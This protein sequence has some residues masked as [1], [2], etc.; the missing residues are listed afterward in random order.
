MPCVYKTAYPLHDRPRS[1]LLTTKFHRR[2]RRIVASTPTAPRRACTVPPQP[3]AYFHPPNGRKRRVRPQLSGPPRTFCN[4]DAMHASE[5]LTAVRLR[6][7]HFVQPYP[8]LWIPLLGVAPPGA[9]RGVLPQVDAAAK[10]WQGVE[11]GGS[12]RHAA[13]FTAAAR[14]APLHSFGQRGRLRCACISAAAPQRF[15]WRVPIPVVASII[16]FLRYMQ[17][18]KLRH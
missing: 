7:H 16:L 13:G 10:G 18:S 14:R 12:C 1:S 9:V 2:R 8:A 11:G 6:S 5:G 17:R 4:A 3:G 15:P